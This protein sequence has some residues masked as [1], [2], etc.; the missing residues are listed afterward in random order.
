MDPA[1]KRL[2]VFASVIGTALLGLVAVWAFTGHHHGGIPVIE[3]DS[4]PV[5]VKPANPGGM[6]VE[7]AND[8]ILSG[9]TAGKETVAPGPE[10]P[11]PLA[12]KA[13]EQAAAQAAAAP[14]QAGDATT[15][16]D[17]QP[18]APA[19]SHKLPALRPHVPV[20]AQN[21]PTG[22]TAT[23]GAASIRLIPGAKPSGP[24]A[25][26]DGG[27]PRPPG[28]SPI[29]LAPVAGAA[30]ASVGRTAM[31]QNAATPDA[32]AEPATPADTAPPAPAAAS[33]GAASA[34]PAAAPHGHR[35]FVQFAAVASGE[36]ALREWQRLSKK[37][38]D[39]LGSK[40]PNITKTEHDGK[41]FWRVR[42]GGFPDVAQATVFCQR[43]KTKGGNCTV[44]TL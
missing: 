8:S 40:S 14:A 13:Q 6:Q 18:A 19:D 17:A 21:P 32:P 35:V 15:T 5:K 23:D 27:A 26:G 9:E 11:A 42:T 44:A 43:V 22:S 28:R 41:I 39:L 37:Y 2:A 38:P 3:A 24:L 4:R 33:P 30:A 20:R 12:L 31:A 1:T 16:A 36:A 25:S 29:P 7:G 34:Q 10:S